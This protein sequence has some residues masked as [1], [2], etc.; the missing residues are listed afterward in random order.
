MRDA[1]VLRERL[2]LAVTVDPFVG[3]YYSVEW[4]KK[5]ILRQSEEDIGIMQEQ[6]D[7]EQAGPMLAPPPEMPP[8][9]NVQDNSGMESP[10]PQLD[11]EVDKYATK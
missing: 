1:E 5:N 9:D 2:N 4:I 6:M 10:T 3:K 7:A 11:T 8:E